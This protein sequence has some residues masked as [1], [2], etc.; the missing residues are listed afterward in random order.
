MN[1]YTGELLPTA[2]TDYE[3]HILLLHKYFGHL[4]IDLKGAI[5]RAYQDFSRSLRGYADPVSRKRINT[6][7]AKKIF[8]LISELKSPTRVIETEAQ[9]D[10]WHKKCVTRLANH[11]RDCGVE[12]FTLGHAQYWVNKA[13]LNLFLLPDRAERGYEHVF[14]ICHAPISQLTLDFLREE[15]FDGGWNGRWSK[16]NSLGPY[17]EAQKFIR[18]RYDDYPL[19]LSVKIFTGAKVNRHEGE[20]ATEEA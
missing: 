12:R 6:M 13:L 2:F 14:H 7:A 17:M 11:Y 4:P 8:M 10:E 3:S 5:G 9:F 15:G 16:L 20:P 19:Q 18:E 1:P